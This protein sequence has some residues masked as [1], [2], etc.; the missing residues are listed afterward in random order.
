MHT[1]SAIAGVICLLAL[2]GCSSDDDNGGAGPT[3]T[4][5]VPPTRTN[6]PVPPPTA[7]PTGD[8][9]LDISICAPDAG[10]FST[11]IDHPFFPLP[12]GAQWVFEGEDEEGVAL[13]L[14]V[15]SFDETKTV[16]GVETRVIEERESEDGE[17]VEVS[18]NYFVRA[19]DGTVCYYGEDVDIYEDGEIVSHDGAWLAG[20]NGNLP[21]ILMPAVPALGQIFQQEVAPGIAEDEAEIVAT[22][23][24][25]EVPFGTFSDT[26]QFLETNP[27]DGGTS[28]KIYARNVGLILDDEFERV[29]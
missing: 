20:E 19:P 12:V 5:T 18:R 3:A 23:E 7:T 9:R 28:D 16:A 14:E 13:H 21:G 6:T 29:E 2:G 15:T 4:A 27:L 26:I 10:P 11:V 25:V 1:R 22:G 8:D 24:T 17:L